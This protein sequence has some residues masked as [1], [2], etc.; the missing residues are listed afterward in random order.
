MAREHRAQGG[1]VRDVG[2]DGRDD[3]AGPGRDE[4]LLRLI[5]EHFALI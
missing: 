1:P 3:G 4:L 5:K 2:D